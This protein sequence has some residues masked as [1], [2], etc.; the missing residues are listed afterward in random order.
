MGTNHIALRSAILRRHWP[1][2]G[3]F[4]PHGKSDAMAF[5]DLGNHS[6]L[7]RRGGI[8]TQ[9]RAATS[10]SS[11]MTRRQ[12][13]A[14]STL[15]AYHEIVGYDNIQ[16]TK[17]PNVLRGMGLTHLTKNDSAKKELAKKGMALDP[18]ILP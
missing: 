7:C 14:P 6:S 17:A 9:I 12:P 1:F 8:R 2:T 15:P 13:G 18:D 5:V 11:S 10:V 4:E 16:F 3:G